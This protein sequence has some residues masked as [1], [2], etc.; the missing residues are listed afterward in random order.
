MSRKTFGILAGM[1]YIVCLCF[2]W[3]SP[4]ETEGGMTMSWIPAAAAAAYL[5]YAIFCV[6]TE[7]RGLDE[8]G[9]IEYG[10]GVWKLRMIHIPGYALFSMFLMRTMVQVGFYALTHPAGS[11]GT[12]Q[13][14]G[15]GDEVLGS[16]L[17]ILLITGAWLL[18]LTPWGLAEYGLFPQIEA[19]GI[20]MALCFCTVSAIVIVGIAARRKRYGL[21]AWKEVLMILAQLVPLAELLGLWWIAVEDRKARL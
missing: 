20:L 16:Y 2:L 13:S 14:G 12:H 1:P 3:G 4:R 18:M 11:S 10:N 17:L 15:S 21:P 9:R 6:V 7:M 5:A 8:Q 19:Y